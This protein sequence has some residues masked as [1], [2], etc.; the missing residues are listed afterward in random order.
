[1]KR[2][3]PEPYTLAKIKVVG[4]GGAGGNAVTRMFGNLPR[5]VDL[6]AINT[7]VQDLN[8]NLAKKKIHIGKNVTRGLGTGM[9]PDLGRQAAE[10]NRTEITESLRGADMVFVT[11]G[12]GGGTGSGAAP[13]I[14]EIARE[15]GILTVA[16]ITK[17][18]TFEG[19]KRS[20]IATEALIKLR[21]RVDTLITIPND[22]IFSLI[23]NDTPMTK[24]FEEIDEVLKNSVQGI[25][26]LIVAPGIVNVDFADVKAIMQD[27]GSAIIGIG[28]ATGAERSTNAAT[29]ALNSPLLDISI[30]GAKGVLFSVS[31]QRDLRMNEVNDIARLISESVDPAAKIIFGT[32]HDRR[33]KKGQ[34]KVT[35]IATGFNG[36]FNKNSY[37][38]PT[39]F[40]RSPSDISRKVDSEA[41]F[42]IVEDETHGRS[43]FSEGEATPASKEKERSAKEKEDVWDIPAF[44][45]KR[46]RK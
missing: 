19:A 35:L 20:Q 32:Y 37:I 45:R 44:M 5:S 10:E 27:S 2:D 21:D 14:A 6:L 1:M 12:F 36:M 40:E 11:A 42:P 31:G 13:V 7:D 46:K 30:D 24:A 29:M 16:V 4:V 22:R 23:D 28:R 41:T 33:L 43:L 17:P 3:K 26:E 15:M 34:I 39:L 18:F 25:T 9:N 8:Y 38:G